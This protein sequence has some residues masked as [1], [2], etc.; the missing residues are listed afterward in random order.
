MKSR[1]IVAAVAAACLA[2]GS[3][4]QAQDGRGDRADRGD[5]Q[6]WQ[7]RDGPRDGQRANREQRQERQERRADRQER[8]GDHAARTHNPQ[9]V[10]RIEG[11]SDHRWDG[12]SDQRWDGRSDHRG[13]A[14]QGHRWDRSHAQFHRGGYVPY[15]Y[16]H[17][18][19]YV[20]D[21]RA[22]HLSPPPYG[23]QWVQSDSGD[24]IL[25]AL[26]TGLIANLIFNGY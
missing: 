4:A 3:L 17:Q 21:W 10:Q 9:Q 14:R 6:G 15:E 2:F 7:Q 24:I 18:R 26:A 5:R 12:R 8:R 13:H 1:A 16:R 19:Y 23:Y 11:R 22:R 20:N 25:M